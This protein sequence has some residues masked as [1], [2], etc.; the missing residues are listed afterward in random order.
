M[1]LLCQRS[2]P[3]FLGF[4]RLYFSKYQLLP[5]W[6]L[7]VCT[8]PNINSFLFWPRLR[9]APLHPCAIIPFFVCHSLGSGC[10]RPKGPG[11][12][13]PSHVLGCLRRAGSKPQQ[14]GQSMRVPILGP[15][16][17]RPYT[18]SSMH[19]SRFCAWL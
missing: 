1:L 10:T 2:T 18:I 14:L 8:S 6:G 4:A 3:F 7:P 5:F 12:T 13:L 19:N 11:C 9:V 16:R 15:G 17:T